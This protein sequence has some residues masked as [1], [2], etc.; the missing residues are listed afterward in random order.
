[1]LQLGARATVQLSGANHVP[2]RSE[3]PAR[4]KRLR[5]GDADEQLCLCPPPNLRGPAGAP[6][7]F[8]ATRPLRYTPAPGCPP[9]RVALV[10]GG[11]A[12]KILASPVEHCPNK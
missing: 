5:A 6:C 4:Y 2:L 1:M 10:R 9:A 8:V 12:G 3:R 7:S 11:A